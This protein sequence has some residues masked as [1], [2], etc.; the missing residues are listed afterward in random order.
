[1]KTSLVIGLVLVVLV[2]FA[3]TPGGA[4]ADT[5]DGLLTALENIPSD[6]PGYARVL[7]TAQADCGAALDRSALVSLYSSTNGDGW[8]RKTNWLETTVLIKVT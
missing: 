4:E 6:T 1:M 8:Y 2:A 3:A 5:C 7:E